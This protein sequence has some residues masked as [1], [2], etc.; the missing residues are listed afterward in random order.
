MSLRRIVASSFWGALIGA[1]LGCLIGLA[2]YASVFLVSEVSYSASLSQAYQHIV[3]PFVALGAFAGLAATGIAALS[4]LLRADRP[5]STTR[6]RISTVSI[7]L[8]LITLAYI[9]IGWVLAPRSVLG[10]IPLTVLLVAAV[11]LAGIVGL[12]A[13]RVLSRLASRNRRVSDIASKRHWTST[14]L[15]ILFVF[16]VITLPPAFFNLSSASSAERTTSDQSR[17]NIIIILVDALRADHLSMYGY[18]RKTSPNLEEFAK[19]AVVFT[20]ASAASSWTKP[21]VATIFS[22]LYPDVH[23]TRTNQDFLSGSVLTLAEALRDSGYETL[24]VTANPLISPTFGFTQGFMEFSVPETMSPFRFTTLGRVARQLSNRLR[25]AERRDQHSDRPSARSARS[26]PKTEAQSS[27]EVE[28]QLPRLLRSSAR[29][30]T[31]TVA[32]VVFGEKVG[33]LPPGDGITDTALEMVE[34]RRQS[35]PLFLYVHY[36]DPHDP[37][38]PPMPYSRAF[39]FRD[40]SPIR[41]GGVDA[42]SFSASEE[43]REWLGESVDLYDGEILFVDS[44]IGRLLSGLESMNLLE[45]AIVM[46]TSDHGE[47]FLDHGGITHGKTLY[48]EVLR[49]PLLL[50]W[51]GLQT[52]GFVY[53]RPIGLVDLMPTI[54]E[55]VGVDSSGPMQGRSL[56]AELAGKGESEDSR[57]YFGQVLRL[58]MARIDEFKLIRNRHKT[59]SEEI[60]NL[61]LDPLERDN[62]ADRSDDGFVEL[63]SALEELSLSAESLGQA[64]DQQK[65]SEEEEALKAL[66]ALGY[67]E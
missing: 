3:Y 8:L 17:P 25:V 20:K 41:Q 16:S 38:S 30:L 53:D 32:E 35:E 62:L 67:I 9:A 56:V 27:E 46:V 34:R 60:Y 55:F 24:G 51:P 18:A 58:E 13:F 47:E 21:S 64:I 33:L 6:F 29:R 23:K 54:L 14:A 57:P 22:S 15:L 10:R 26:E 2:E 49:V 12:A 65:V 1:F 48:E 5:R 28:S 40:D 59:G 42:M 31:S 52:P 4:A 50:A 7:L 11:C 63:F 37:Y 44:Q 43:E 61:D 39:S 36:I 45:D 66:R 19:R